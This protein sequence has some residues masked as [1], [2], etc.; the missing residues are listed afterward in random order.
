MQRRLI[1]LNEQAL[2]PSWTKAA[3]SGSVEIEADLS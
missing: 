1:L 3:S 2:A